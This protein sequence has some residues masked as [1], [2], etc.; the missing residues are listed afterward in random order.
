MAL[1]T[2]LELI[3]RGRETIAHDTGPLNK[4]HEL[5]YSLDLPDGSTSGKAN[6]IW[7]DV[8][9]L[10]GTEDIDIAGGLTD[11]SG[12]TI[13]MTTFNGLLVWNKTS[14]VLTIGGDASAALDIYADSSDALEVQAGGLFAWVAPNA[15]VTV[16]AGTS[17]VLQIS[18]ATAGD[19]LIILFGRG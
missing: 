4:V 12:A 14:G 9:T 10:D 6:K 7:S 15:G 1:K 8:R 18:T 3:F 17:D 19:Y 13:T 16:G 11:V 2:E 5:L